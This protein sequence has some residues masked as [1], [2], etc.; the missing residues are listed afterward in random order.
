VTQS[1]AA[2]AEQSASAEEELNAQADALKESVAELLQLVGGNK[3]QKMPKSS[4][5]SHQSSASDLWK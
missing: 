2:N 5:I 1:N 3:Q 4:A